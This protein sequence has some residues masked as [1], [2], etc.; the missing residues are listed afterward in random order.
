M[1]QASFAEYIGVAL[2]TLVVWESGKR[3]T[4]PQ[5]V[6]DLLEYKLRHQGLLK[7]KGEVEK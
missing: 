6:L 1:T 7:S 5:F 2:G 3:T 4:L